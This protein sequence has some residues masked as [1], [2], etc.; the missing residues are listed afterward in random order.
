MHTLVLQHVSLATDR[1][2]LPETA[3]CAVE[4]FLLERSPRVVATAQRAEPLEVLRDALAAAGCFAV[5]RSPR[6]PSGRFL[7]AQDPADASNGAGFGGDSTGGRPA[8]DTTGERAVVDVMAQLRAE[9]ARM[10]DVRRRAGGRGPLWAGLGALLLLLAGSRI[11][12]ELREDPEDEPLRPAEQAQPARDEP[13][14]EPDEDDPP[15]DEQE[16]PAEPAVRASTAGGADGPRAGE[17]ALTD[18]AGQ[19]QAGR[20]SEQGAAVAR[21][22]ESAAATGDSEG[23]PGLARTAIAGLGL[24]AF[25]LG[26]L[27][28]ARRVA[29]A[30]GPGPLLRFDRGVV[31]LAAAGVLGCGAAA[32]VATS[33]TPDP[34]APPAPA[35]DPDQGS[36][37]GDRP[38]PGA[39]PDGSKT[40]G[41]GPAEPAADA[42]TPPDAEPSGNGEPTVAAFVRALDAHEPLSYAALARAAGGIGAEVAPTVARF[43]EGLGSV[44]RH[45]SFAA[46]ADS[47]PRDSNAGRAALVGEP[48]SEAT[49]APTAPGD[50]APREAGAG[51][52]DHAADSAEANA[53]RPTAG[54]PD[55]GAETRPSNAGSRAANERSSSPGADA[56]GPQAAQ[57]GPGQHPP[58][59]ERV[60]ENADEHG[61]GQGAE[62]PEG[63]T[64]GRRGPRSTPAPASAARADDTVRH[65]GLLAPSA[66]GA[67]FALLLEGLLGLLRLTRRREVQDA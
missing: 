60:A 28:S 47:A 7:A 51:A 44:P 52:Q 1:E 62:G 11:T 24:F 34:L 38:S 30:R 50:A 23:D 29:R 55:H 43:V 33:R 6:T 67:G 8:V 27:E 25:V 22:S 49:G 41:A 64:S 37:A 54:A 36:V 5:I 65:A 31:A 63:T 58:S 14:R 20:D 32:L 42:P 35:P 10:G 15:P 57:G 12:C 61:G 53:P 19:A 59:G 26:G 21:A 9:R 3:R 40:G 45:A 48:V 18:E 56:P 2:Q 4:A 13:R 66:A 16:P 17:P 46:I 39:A